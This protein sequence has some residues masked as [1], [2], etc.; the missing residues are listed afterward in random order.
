MLVNIPIF[1]CFDIFGGVPN[2]HQSFEYKR[3]LFRF[4]GHRDSRVPPKSP[5]LAIQYY[6]IEKNDR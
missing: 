6:Y 2:K 1:A 3:H 5:N 4:A